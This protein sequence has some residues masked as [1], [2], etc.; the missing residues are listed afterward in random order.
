MSLKGKTFEEIDGEVLMTVDPIQ[1]KSFYNEELY[2]NI[3]KT[4]Y[5]Y[6][7]TETLLKIL[8]N[9]TIRLHN[10]AKSNDKEE[11]VYIK[12]LL[13]S[14]LNE[15]RNFYNEFKPDNENALDEKLVNDFVDNYFER[16]TRIYFAVCFSR[17]SNKLSQ[18]DRYAD[19]GRGAAIGFDSESLCK[20]QSMNSGYI[21]GKVIY[22]LSELNKELKNKTEEFLSDK[23]SLT[24]ED[25]NNFAYKVLHF[26]SY[27]APLYKNPYF[28]DE[29]EWRLVFLPTKHFNVLDN[30]HLQEWLKEV[31]QDEYLKESC[32]F[33]R[34]PIKYAISDNNVRSYF[35]LNFNNIKKKLIKEIVI[36]PSS[37][38]DIYDED[39]RWMLLQHGYSFSFKGGVNRIKLSKIYESY[40]SKM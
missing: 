35:D 28:E 31:N 38:I 16:S 26:M 32:G 14:N 8:N 4:L 30:L 20:L 39:L 40:R 36:G 18:W 10:I 1:L 5:H 15:I 29:E 23:K 11:L 21:F 2:K 6:C 27:Y 34:C 37:N 12:P 3:P 7:S 17:N 22:G 13:K 9:S 33:V 19:K 25:F 24:L